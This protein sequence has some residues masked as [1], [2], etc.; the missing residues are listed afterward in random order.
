VK[1][2]I[3]NML[4]LA[5]L[6]TLL[7][8]CQSEDNSSLHAQKSSPEIQENDKLIV[9][10]KITNI[11]I[12]KTKGNGFV[13]END[14][15][16]EKVKGIISSAIKEN[17]IVNMANPEYYMDV[18]YENGKKQSFHLWIGERGQNTTLMDTDDTHTIYTVSKEMSE[19]LIDIVESN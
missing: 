11:S 12:S 16:I 15:I 6:S 14:E 1:K 18:V 13:F 17:G 3:L 10:G 8:G 19:K 2:N 7:F 4:T 5:L 9:G